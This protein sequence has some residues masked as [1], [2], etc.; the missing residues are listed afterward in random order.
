MDSKEQGNEKIKKIVKKTIDTLS[1]L[2]VLNYIVYRFLQ[3]TMFPLVYTNTYKLFTTIWMIIAGLLHFCFIFIEQYRAASEREDKAKLFFYV[4]VCVCIS[5][6]FLYVAKKYN[7]KF[8]VFLPLVSLCLY[9]MNPEKVLRSTACVIS[10]LFISTWICALSGSVRNLTYAEN[11]R[12]FNAFGIINTTDFAAYFTYLFLY[13]WCSHRSSNAIV[14]FGL[15]LMSLLL[16]YGVFFLSSSRT[17]LVCG[18]LTT[19]AILWNVLNNNLLKHWD[20][21]RRFGNIINHMTI[22]AFPF[23]GFVFFLL[24][25]QYAQLTEF[26]KKMDVLTAGRLLATWT[27]YTTYGIHPF[28]TSIQKMHGMGGSLIHTWSAGYGYIDVAYSMMAIR[29]GWVITLIIMCLWVWTTYRAVR[30]GKTKIALAMAIIS[31]HAFAE[32][33]FL[34]LNYNILLAMSFCAYNR[35]EILREKRVDIA[36][37]KMQ[38]RKRIFIYSTICMLIPVLVFS[39]RIFSWLRTIFYLEGLREGVQGIY[40]LLICIELVILLSAMVWSFYY[41]VVQKSQKASIVIWVSIVL[42]CIIIGYGNKIITDGI[43]YQSE[44]LVSE[45][46]VI[47]IVQKSSSQ[48]VYAAEA[49]EMYQRQFGGFKDHAFSTEELYRNPKGTIF[50]DINVECLGILATGGK[51]AQ[52]SPWSGVYSYDPDVIETLS[53]EGF[54]WESYYYTERICNLEDLAYRN[55]LCI[56]SGK[57]R[58]SG[59]EESIRQGLEWDQYAG[60][61]EVNYTLELLQQGPGDAICR[62]RVT[63]EAGEKI[64]LEK[65]VTSD[66]FDTEGICRIS[67]TYVTGDVPKVSYLLEIIDETDLFVK[68]I[69]WRRIS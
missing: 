50:T 59:S 31:A 5:I 13:L 35:S 47:R 22:G 14:D 39:P 17:A 48:P 55:D 23:V 7:Y 18:I 53:S 4:S 32:A 40:A 20:R 1:L 33:R 54:R 19:I 56:E 62:I 25:T 64:L 26:S 68:E 42:F 28:G 36:G 69:S 49:S 51:Y 15:A 66:D 16:S 41:T 12:I 27:P 9:K 65:M 43:N 58:L 45:E 21:T 63:G 29:Y 11:D 34:D 10:I 24:M 30:S 37:V 61:Y 3:S 44:R 46:S 2:A 52:I 8:L 38:K 67:L 60:T 6:P 57:L